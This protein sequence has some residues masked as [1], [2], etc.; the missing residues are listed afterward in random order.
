M[1]GK[2]KFGL[3]RVKQVLSES[4]LARNVFWTMSGDGVRLF[5][6]AF[7]F[8]LIGRALGAREFGAFVGAVALVALV[9]PF[10]SWGTGFILLKEVA[11]DRGAFSRC[12]GM[13]LSTTAVFGSVLLC[14]VLLVSRVAFGTA[15]PLRALLLVAISDAIVVRVLDLATQAFTAVENLRTGAGIYVALSVARTLAAIYL[16][17]AVPSPSAQS[18][19]LL[20]LISTCAAAIYAI[21]AV[22]RAFGRPRLRLHFSRPEFRE[23][24]YF[25]VSQ[26]SQTVYNDLDKTML[27]RF[28]GLEATGIY[29]AAYRIVD[30]SFA[31]VSALT[32]ATL[33]RFFRQGKSGI[34]GSTRF[35]RKI[36]PYSVSYGLLAAVFLFVASPILPVLLGPGFI[37]ATTALRWLSP[38]VFLKSI[39][40]FLANS[41]SGAGH[42]GRRAL[43]QIGTVVINVVLNLWLIRAY[44]WRGAAW[45]SLA[46]DGALV[47]GLL[48]AIV[49]I[50]GTG[51]IPG[52]SHKVEAEAKVVL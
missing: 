46:S 39:H 41:L 7:Y 6:Q 49:S 5:L 30:V 16:T 28:G 2:N 33:A 34:A 12:W 11:R 18:W 24:F 50:R 51:T 27:V 37:M 26:A 32:Q 10:S 1:I 45:A 29:G 40:Y 43:V 4:A 8:V 42:Q 23:G 38:L 48:V 3:G 20:Y 13:A 36:L 25:A 15:V 47:L 31:P 19:A 14:L 52:A 44:S 17:L 21:G 22:T 9:A 35:A